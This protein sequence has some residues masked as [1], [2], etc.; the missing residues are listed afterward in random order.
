MAPSTRNVA[1]GG[2]AIDP[3][4][5]NYMQS[6]LEDALAGIRETL[7]N[8]TSAMET[9]GSQHNP[10]MPNNQM[11]N[12]GM[13]RTANQF[14]RLAK[15]EFPKFHGSNVRD[16]AFRCEQFFLI[17]NTPEV[18]KV[19]IASV[20]LDEKALLWHRQF[21]RLVGENV[22]W[23]MYKTAI[24]QRFG[25]VFE[26]PM[27]ELKNAK[28]DKSAKEYQDLFDTLL[29]RV[30]ISPENALSLYLGGLPTELEMEVRMFKPRTLADAYYLTNLQEATLEAARKK[31]RPVSNMGGGRFGNGNVMRPPL[32]PTPVQ[33]SFKPKPNNPTNAPMRKQLTQKEYQ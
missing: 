27:A 28:S 3:N 5:R 31:N 21:V 19:K 32:L 10:N 7:A 6:T 15:V 25:S 23:E 1:A 8:L 4:I 12:L 11:M 18:E 16:W 33:N 24:I 26:D 29:C 13:G 9:M 20:H 22:G 17:D 14:S 30:D 2:D